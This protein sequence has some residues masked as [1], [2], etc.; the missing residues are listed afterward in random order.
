MAGPRPQIDS[1]LCPTSLF[2]EARNRTIACPGPALCLL[3]SQTDTARPARPTVRET[4]T[5]PASRL[6]RRR[7]APIPTRTRNGQPAGYIVDLCTEVAAALGSEHQS[8]STCGCRADRRLEFV[9]DGRVLCLSVPFFATLPRREIVDFSLP[10]LPD[11]A[12]PVTRTRKF[13]VRTSRRSWRQT[14]RRPRWHE[15]KREKRCGRRWRRLKPQ[16]RGFS[17]AN[18]A[19]S[20]ASIF[21]TDDKV[22]AYFADRGIIARHAAGGRTTRLLR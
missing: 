19:A 17:L 4:G 20:R 11:G 15:T 9:S 18:R 10:T 6:P 14:G 7:P 8:P 22:D 16:G 21:L 3:A 1:R 2:I 5:V 12:V 13:P